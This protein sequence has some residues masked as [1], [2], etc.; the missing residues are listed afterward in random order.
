MPLPLTTMFCGL[1]AAFDTTATDPGGARP[2][3]AGVNVTPTV[4][5]EFPANVPGKELF[6][7]VVEG[8]MA[9]P[10]AGAVIEVMLRA[11]DCV[12]VRVNDLIRLV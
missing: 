4:Q 3:E 6:A 7:Q 2:R 12:F 11:V 1:L 8:S 5:E 10:P 9:N